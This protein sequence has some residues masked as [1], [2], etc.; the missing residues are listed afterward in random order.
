ME[1]TLSA[2]TSPTEASVSAA[3]GVV[4]AVVVDQPSLASEVLR[5]V[6]SGLAAQDYPNIQILVLLTGSDAAEFELVREIAQVQG[7]EPSTREP[8]IYHIGANPGFGLAANMV[9]R[10]VEGDSG[11]FLLM[12]DDVVLAPDAV[13]QLVEEMYR[14][15]AGMVGP[16][17]VE[18]DETRRLQSVGFDC[19]W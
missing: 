4:V 1:A 3:P 5:E 9:M 11:F 6:F 7:S 18:W 16:K 2:A 14:S 12:H 19:D 8:R 15:N 10:L 13:R 17:F